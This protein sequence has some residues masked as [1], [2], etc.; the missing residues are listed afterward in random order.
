MKKEAVGVL[1]GTFD[2]VHTGHLV[3]ARE[4]RDG[5]NLGKVLFIPAGEPYF[6]TAE[7]VTPA[8]HR[9]KMVKLATE[10]EDDFIA[11]DME[12]RRS[13]LSYTVD[14]MVELKEKAGQEGDIYFILGWDN[15][16][17]LPRWHQPEKLISL[18]KLVAVPRVGYPPPDL[19]KLEATIPGISKRVLMFDKPQID[20]CASVIRQRVA[21]GLS[22]E[23]LVPKKVAEYIR[24]EGLYL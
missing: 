16:I 14:T 24:K 5:L 9:L 8:E 21:E 11:S 1:G 13:G 22:I 10:G 4:I 6:K 23:H 18:C 7:M 20:I 12:I 15:L 2:P 17:D 19:K 3:V